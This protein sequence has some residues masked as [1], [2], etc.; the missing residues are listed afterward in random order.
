MCRLPVLILFLILTAL[1][2]PHAEA[3]KGPYPE[4]T[5]RVVMVN[6]DQVVGVIVR[7]TE[8]EIEVEIAGGARMTIPRSQVREVVSLAGARFARIDPN[9]SRLFFAPTARPLEKGAGY[10]AAYE[11]FF[12]F[13]AY[14]ASSRFT[15]AGGV[16]LIPGLSGQLVYFAPKFTLVDGEHVAVAG[17]VMANT[18]IGDFDDDDIPLF[19]LAYAVTTF[20]GAERAI[21]AGLA[22]GYADGAFGEH[23]VILLGGEYQLSDRVKLLTENYVIVGVEDAIGLSGGIRFFGDRLAADLGLITSPSFIREVD[24]FPFF[25]W[26]GFV[27]NFGR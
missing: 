14:G 12:P 23:P 27:Y 10:L 15:L 18:V 19:G 26:L 2:A 21:T 17:G 9:R 24:G 4:G 11:L 5:V 7:D 22:V 1:A 3:Q 25:P 16:S 13:V 20:G 6:G 8:A